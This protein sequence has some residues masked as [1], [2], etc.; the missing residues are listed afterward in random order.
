MNYHWARIGETRHAAGDDPDECWL[1]SGVWAAGLFVGWR[2][3]WPVMLWYFLVHTTARRASQAFLQRLDPTLK[4]QPVA[5]WV[6]LSPL[7]GLWR[8]ADG[9]RSK[10]VSGHIA[11]ERL[12]GSGVERFTQDDR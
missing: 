5:R 4:Q 3:Y 12:V 2:Y 8:N 7:S 1:S 9:T 6:T 10:R 11:D